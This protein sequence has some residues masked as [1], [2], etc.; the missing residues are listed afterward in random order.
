MFLRHLIQ[1]IIEVEVLHI[2]LLSN[3][4]TKILP[5]YNYVVVQLHHRVSVGVHHDPP[6]IMWHPDIT[7]LNS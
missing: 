1:P 3:L 4:L 7:I 2:A 5:A 6:S